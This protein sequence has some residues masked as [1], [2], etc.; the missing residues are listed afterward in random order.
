MTD[1]AARATRLAFIRDH[2]PDRGGDPDQFIEGLRRLDDRIP[3]PSPTG[4]TAGAVSIR[5]RGPRGRASWWV[6]RTAAG[7]AARRRRRA[8]V[9]ARRL[10]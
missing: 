5:R 3:A 9:P 8:R 7:W 10:Q 2:H 1:A 6:L 4:R